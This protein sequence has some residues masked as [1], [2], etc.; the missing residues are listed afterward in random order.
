MDLLVERNR[1]VFNTEIK[2]GTLIWAKHDGWESGIGGFV[3][4][5]SEDEL[6][7]MFHPDI[8]NVVNHY[9]IPA[10]EAAD[11]K[12]QIRWSEDL[13]TVNGLAAEGGGEGEAGGPDTEEAAREPGPDRQAG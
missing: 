11:G 7:V 1:Y 10:E 12:W 4:A 8:S 2:K 9:I 13:V 6:V 3:S 5:V